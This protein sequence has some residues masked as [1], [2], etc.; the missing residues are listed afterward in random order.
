M[1]VGLGVKMMWP[2]A[3]QE[4]AAGGSTELEPGHFLCAALKLA[5]MPAAVFQNILQD[6]RLVAVLEE[7]QRGLRQTL[8]G[9]GLRV[10]ADSTPFRRRLRRLL[11]KDVHG[12]PKNRGEVI[13][14]S[15]AARALFARAEA[16]A[17][18][19]GEKEIAPD[20]L[21]EILLADPDQDLAAALARV[22]DLGLAAGPAAGPGGM[23][24]LE[25]YGADLTGRAREMQSDA[26]RLEKI[27]C[28]AVCRVLAEGLFAGPGGQRSPLLLISPGE[29]TAAAVVNDLAH[30]LVSSKPPTGFRRGRLLEI[31]SAAILNRE[32]E[33]SPEARLEQIFQRWEGSKSTLLFFDHFHRYLTPSLA[34]EGPLR[35]FQTFLKDSK[36]NCILGMTKKQYEAHIEQ[37]VSWRKVFRLIW[38]HDLSPN[39]QL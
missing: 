36:S 34:G 33:G 31:H 10:P 27:R 8:A 2:L 24:W 13:H 23:E 17:Q 20:R 7:D 35:R 39:F 18:V 14:R 37:A 4:A 26:T 9:L 6:K 5:E 3:A 11:R 28:D 38:I 22:G 19:A 16:E 25:A 12:G 29:R 32:S 21:V 30:W 15:A 1:K